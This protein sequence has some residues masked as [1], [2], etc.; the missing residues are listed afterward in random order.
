MIAFQGVHQE[1]L[2]D[3]T[4]EI[5]I[6]GSLSCGKTTVCLFKE[7][8][9]TQRYPGIHSLIAR[10]TDDATNTLLRPALEQMGRICGVSLHWNDKLK[11]YDLENGSRI[12]S[13][14]L[15][16]QSQDPEQRYGKIRGLPVSR[17]YI[18]QAEQLPQDIASELRARLRPDLEARLRGDG[19]P[20]QLT[21]SPNPT[22]FD[23]WLS[24][25]F[26]NNGSIK[27]RAYYALSLFS[28]AHNLSP[29]MIASMLTEYP[30]EHPKFTTVVMGQRGLNVIGE[31]VY[32]N[33]FDRRI[34]VKAITPMSDA[35]LIE[36]FE[37]GKH[38]PVWV[39]GQRTYQGGLALLGGLFGRRLVLEDFLP[40][41][42]QHR[43]EWFDAKTQFRTCVTP[44]GETVGR[45]RYT[46]VN[47]LREAGFAPVWR[48]NTNAHDVQLAMIEQIAAMLRRR[49]ATREEAIAVNA[50]PTRWTNVAQDGTLKA[51]PFLSFAFEGGYVCSP[52]TVSVSNKAM[53]QPH[54]DDEYANVMRCVEN[55]VLNF[56]AGQA[57]EFDRDTRLQKARD[58]ETA[59]PF[60]G[61]GSGGWMAY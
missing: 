16:T 40:I 58:R 2:D 23:H 54:Y 38:N 57:S 22:N 30:E 61:S 21:F 34:H 28:N 25:Q 46:L 42:K 24:K 11:H 17:I 9:A 3:T 29:E 15:K 52:H 51:I 12:Y 48:E 1:F 18:D 49:T 35:P 53:R 33:L 8:R 26:P 5:D 59:N 44:M 39:V 19:F 20:T 27:G 13:F 37:F 10:W 41:V 6:E 36:A 50:D 7:I 4:P 45:E 32:E 43:A 31:A 14:G 60:S 55:L 47:V 56:C